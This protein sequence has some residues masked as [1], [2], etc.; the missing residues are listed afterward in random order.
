MS[1]QGV[2]G[3]ESSKDGGGRSRRALKDMFKI[4]GFIL[5]GCV[6]MAGVYAGDGSMQIYVSESYIWYVDDGKEGKSLFEGRET[7]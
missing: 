4:W 6:A 2:A 1:K 3:H 7:S 5:W